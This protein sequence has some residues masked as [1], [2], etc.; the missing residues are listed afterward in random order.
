MSEVEEFIE[1]PTEEAF[2]KL[3]KA[4]LITVA[5]HYEVSL[6][7]NDKRNKQMLKILL[8]EALVKKELM[9]PATDLEFNLTLSFEQQKELLLLQ[10][11][12]SRHQLQEQQ[13]LA[14]KCKFEREIELGKQELERERLA[15]ERKRLALIE[16]GKI[17]SSPSHPDITKNIRL[18]PK[19][20]E[21]DVDTFFNL[22]ERVADLYS[23]EDTTRCLLLQCALVGR[24]AQA[25]S[26]LG[27][28]ESRKYAS[29]KR[30]VLKAYELVPE[31]YRQKF[32]GMRKPSDQSYVEFA[33][34]LSI[35]FKRWCTSTEVG[36]QEDLSNL[37]LVEQFKN[38]L[39]EDIATYISEHQVATVAEAAVL[40][41]D[42]ALIH[43]TK[44]A[45]A[46]TP[47][48]DRSHWVRQ[49]TRQP[50]LKTISPPDNTRSGGS[51]SV[52]DP[53]RIC[54]YCGGVGHWKFECEELKRKN[55]DK[56]QY[57]DSTT[58]AALGSAL[59]VSLSGQTTAT[60]ESDIGSS[61]APFI[62]DGLVSLGDNGEKVPIKIL[63][64]TGSVQS[65]I[66][67]SVLPFSSRSD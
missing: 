60:I 29:V 66:L 20:D 30:A 41:D 55:R 64:D 14:E 54:N 27:T 1:T 57:R 51:Q 24:A 62:S 21:A 43:K 34:E 40:A 59:A 56:S 23:W 17:G 26:A 25:Y 13:V 7:S 2:G 4:Q 42:Y 31:A 65:F 32:R 50:Q 63:R 15:I 18:L 61:F 46:S 36:S 6:T 38:C 58:G 11:D 16:E 12:K 53:N 39:P 48:N 5:E 3:S 33:D 37:V 19:F 49:G 22:F 9:S 8:R 52:L 28:E 45:Y 35:Q 67:Q 44:F 10:L 47:R